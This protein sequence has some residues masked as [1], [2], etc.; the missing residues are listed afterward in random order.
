MFLTWSVVVLSV[1]RMTEH[2]VSVRRDD[3]AEEYIEQDEGRGGN[4]SEVPKEDILRKTLEVLAPT[5]GHDNDMCREHAQLFQD[6]V[7]RSE[8]WAL[9][10]LDASVKP[11]DTWS[12][13][14][15]TVL[16]GNY[17]ECVSIR[18][19]NRTGQEVF[20]GQY[21]LVMSGHKTILPQKVGPVT[22]SLC[23]PWSCESVDIQAHLSHV[24][25]DKVVFG[26][27]LFVIIGSTIY[28]YIQDKK[29]LPDEEIYSLVSN[30]YMSITP[31]IKNSFR[32]ILK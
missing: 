17:N 10:M 8:P 19:L 2:V 14:E 1:L 32:D 9:Q 23:A 20:G 18:G 31:F 27:F 6:G 25:A 12:L 15:S 22:W 11:T 16:L 30:A 21:C 7:E 24:F 28:D 5:S 3:Y 26:A 13:G 4:I 29:K